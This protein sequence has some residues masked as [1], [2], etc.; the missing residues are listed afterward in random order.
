[1]IAG[2]VLYGE[3]LLVDLKHGGKYRTSGIAGGAKVMT[4]G[5]EGTLRF[6]TENGESVGLVPIE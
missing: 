1:M 2:L 3:H 6:A 4:A 5:K